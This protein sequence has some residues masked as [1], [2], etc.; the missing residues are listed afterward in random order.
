VIDFL[1]RRLENTYLVDGPARAES[2]LIDADSARSLG[3][4]VCSREALLVAEGDEGV[5]V[6]L[7]IE[8]KLLQRVSTL[9]FDRALLDDLG[10]LCELAEGVS[11]FLYCHFL[12]FTRAARSERVVSLLEMEAQAEIDKFVLC[13]LSRWGRDGLQWA[14][15]FMQALFERFQLRAGL[16]HEVRQRYLMANLVARRYCQKLLRLVEQL[17]LSRFLNEVRHSYRMGAEAK[18]LYLNGT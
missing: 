16:S 18:M 13:V 6:A 12:Y 14:K 2:F 15:K 5:E 3:H 11:H 7:Y 10:G 1:Q 9:G 17:D 4:H 8:P